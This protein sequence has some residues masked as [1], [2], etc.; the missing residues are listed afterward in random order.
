VTGKL[1]KSLSKTVQF[2]TLEALPMAPPL[3]AAVKAM[4]EDEIEARAAQDPDAGSIPIGFWKNAVLVEP[5]GSEQI[6]LR[7]PRRVLRHFKAT[8]KGYQSRIN[9]VLESYVDAVGRKAG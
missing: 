6:T 4:S 3:S 5:E 2:D 7:I 1:T 9:A 8:G